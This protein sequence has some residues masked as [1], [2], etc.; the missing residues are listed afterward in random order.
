MVTA[1]QGRGGGRVQL[2]SN[3]GSKSIT[4]IAGQE[5]AG[6]AAAARGTGKGGAM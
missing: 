6:R 5:A 4:G 2:Y 1:V 3:S